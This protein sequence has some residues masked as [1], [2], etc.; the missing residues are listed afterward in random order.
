MPTL[1]P[2]AV[3]AHKRVISASPHLHGAQLV[4]PG[5][6]WVPVWFPFPSPPYPPLPLAPSTSPLLS[7]TPS[8]PLLRQAVVPD[9]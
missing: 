3:K 5:Q 4:A 8:L 7:P 1:L 9:I 2:A 6:V